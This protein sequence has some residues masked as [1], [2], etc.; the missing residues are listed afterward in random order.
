MQANIASPKKILISLVIFLAAGAA[1]FS[2]LDFFFL[3]DDSVDKNGG[4]VNKSSRHQARAISDR[5]VLGVNI[6]GDKVIYYSQS[7]GQVYQSAWDGRNSEKISDS[8]IPGLVSV[9]WAPTNDKVINIV[10]QNHLNKKYYYDYKTNESWLLDHNIRWVDWSPD[11]RKIAYQYYNS[12]TG[13]NNISIADPDGSNWES[14]IDIRMDDLIVEWIDDNQILFRNKPINQRLISV[15]LLNIQTRELKKIIKDKYGLSVLVSP[16][17]DKLIF[18]ETDNQGQNPRLKLANLNSGS[19]QQLNFF[20]LPEKCSW[21]Q[22]NRTLF[23]AVPKSIPETAKLPDDYYENKIFFKDNLWKIN[24]DTREVTEIYQ[25]KN[26]DQQFY[27]IESLYLPR[28]EDYLIF[29]N[30]RDGLLYSLE[31]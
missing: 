28:M 30:Q 22:D 29:I 18:S 3:G 17:G 7:D 23:C 1:V 24:L 6:K 14:L 8:L 20:T 19:I 15:Y 31:L 9:L 26:S 2:S 27:D 25:V 4:N 21:S 16:E 5:A 12:Q 10:R 11:G 13:D